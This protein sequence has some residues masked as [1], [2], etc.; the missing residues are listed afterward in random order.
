MGNGVAQEAIAPAR[1]PA[2]IIVPLT[3]RVMARLPGP[4]WL[5]MVLWAAWL[6]I[7]LVVLRYRF[8]VLLSVLFTEGETTL[9]FGFGTSYTML[10]ALWAVGKL[11][12]DVVALGPTVVRLTQGRLAEGEPFRA[13]GSAW[14]PLVF[15]AIVTIPYG[16][17]EF[18]KAPSLAS[19]LLVLAGFIGWLPLVTFGWVAG[20]VLLGLHRLGGTPLALPAFE[21]DRSLGLRP[22]GSLAFTPLVAYGAVVTPVFFLTGLRDIRDAIVTLGM[23]LVI[24]VLFFASLRRLR[25]QLLAAKARHLAWARSLFQHVLDPM[26][27][28]DGIAGLRNG[29]LELVAAEAIER[30]AAA[31]QEWPFDESILR[32]I[33][34]IV[35]SVSTAI[36]VRLVLSR[37]GL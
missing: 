32:G 23:L 20:A 6:L 3:E 18:L 14:G 1:A 27:T 2:E 21:V 34:A 8:P 13:V 17:V 25:S 24:V 4:R 15:M 16:G 19:A 26:R 9:T 28:G 36:V 10:V 11:G 31:I 12:R 22:F 7:I 5:W 30:R 37:L 33:V 29:A 35:T